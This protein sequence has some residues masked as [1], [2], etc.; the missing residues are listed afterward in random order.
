MGAKRLTT[1]KQREALSGMKASFLS[2]KTPAQVDNYIDNN[3]TDLASA[4]AVIKLMAKAILY[5]AKHS[6]LVK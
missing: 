4:K 1:E 2:G 5:I 3:V 6:N